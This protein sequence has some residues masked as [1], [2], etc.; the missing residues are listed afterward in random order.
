MKSY[1]IDDLDTYLG[2]ELCNIRLHNLD[3]VL[4]AS[5]DKYVHETVMHIEQNLTKELDSRK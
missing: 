2:A 4:L 5:T 1:S 3:E